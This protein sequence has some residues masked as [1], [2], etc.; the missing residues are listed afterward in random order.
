MST[1]QPLVPI[2]IDFISAS[3]G[4]Q[5]SLQTFSSYHFQRNITTPASSFRF[6]APGISV[7]QRM[8]VRSGDRAELYVTSGHPPMI[9]KK[10]QVATGFVDETDTHTSGTS[11]EYVVS[12]RDTS[13]QLVDNDA[14]DANNNIVFIK[15]INLVGIAQLF[16]QNTRLA[17]STIVN[18]NVPNG[19][20]LLQTNVGESKANALQRYLEYCNCLMWSLPTGQIAIG[21]PNM[22]QQPSGNLICAMNSSSNPAANNVLDMRCR[23]NTNQAIRQIAVQLQPLSPTNPTLITQRNQDRDVIALSQARVGRSVYRVYTLGNGMDA[24]NTLSKVGNSITGGNS[25]GNQYAK[26]QIAEENMK[27]I[28]VQAVVAGHLNEYGVPYNTDQVY[29]VIY[30]DEQLYEPM[31][32]YD[33]TYELTEEQGMTTTL[34]LCRLGTIVADTGQVG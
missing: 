16:L 24:V 29:N 9:I 15:S 26:R 32:V 7:E 27:V 20:L 8:R 21:K 30:D 18:F 3:T 1:Y 28:D 19:N 11:V 34:K 23:R 22:T 31:Y 25:I 14:V 12:G 13:S 17:S 4:A 6:T 2:G 10:I 5:T 33:V